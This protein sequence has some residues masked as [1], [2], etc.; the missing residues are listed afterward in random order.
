MRRIVTILCLLVLATATWAKDKKLVKVKVEVVDQPEGMQGSGEGGGAVGAAVGNG[1]ITD[2]S[3]MRVIV[4][5]EHVILEC[6]E[7]R[8]PCHFLGIG[9]YD[10]ELETHPT[11]PKS[12]VWEKYVGGG[13][14]KDPDLWI[15][16]I[17]P[18]DHVDIRE[19]WKVDG[20]WSVG[21]KIASLG[22]IVTLG[23]NGAEIT[24]V[25]TNS[26]A[27]QAG[28]HSGDVINSVNGRAV[29]T[30]MELAAEIS[31][32]HGD[33]IRLGYMI[34]GQWQTETEVILP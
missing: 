1:V 2:A 8:H 3:T 15:H 16:Y 20:S 25:A 14:P 6:D 21:T 27:A 5:G 29:N 13:Q 28:L 33:K 18:N 12:K 30:P 19:H 9:T 10:G 26:A 22:V 24:E 17:G 11:H 7:H 23:Q 34:H 4:N 32:R 31:S